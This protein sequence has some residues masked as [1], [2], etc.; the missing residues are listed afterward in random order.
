MH[1]SRTMN[2]IKI[3]ASALVLAFALE[4]VAFAA[5]A[6]PS[7]VIPMQPL[8]VNFPKDVAHVDE[9]YNGSSANPRLILIQ[10]AHT[11]V[12][13]QLN[14]AE[15]ISELVSE[16]K[17]EYVFTEAG[18]GDNSLSALR[19]SASKKIR[20]QIGLEYLRKGRLKGTEYLSLA[21]DLDFKIW[22][23]EDPDL[24]KN[25][26]DAYKFIAENRNATLP[27]LNTLLADSQFL[28]EKIF[29][30]ELRGFDSL[31]LKYLNEKITV[32]DYISTLK[33]Y[34]DS[35]E[36]DIFPAFKKLLEIQRLEKNVRFEKTESERNRFISAF[37][38]FWSRS[39]IEPSPEE[40][41]GSALESIRK[42]G[43]ELTYQHFKRKL[44]LLIASGKITADSFKRE[45]PDLS[46]YIDYADR[47]FEL[48]MRAVVDE[49]KNLE[50]Y[51]SEKL[52]HSSEE[53]DLIRA[54][55]N[56]RVYKKLLEMQAT[57]SEYRRAKFLS[58][59][60]GYTETV[61]ILNRLLMNLQ[62]YYEKTGIINAQLQSSISTS[63]NFYRLAGDR[64][65]V[66]ISEAL[67]KL[68]AEKQSIAILVTGGFHTPNLTE[69]LRTRNISYISLQ[70]QISHE[71]DHD[72]YE[73]M[74]LHQNL[75]ASWKKRVLAQKTSAVS[76]NAFSMDLLNVV[77]RDPV[78]FNQLKLALGA[79]ETQLS[80]AGPAVDDG[81]GSVSGEPDAVSGFRKYAGSLKVSAS[82]LAESVKQRIRK[83]IPGFIPDFIGANAGARLAGQYQNVTPVRKKISEAKLYDQIIVR[84]D[85]KGA[86]LVYRLHEWGFGY[87]MGHRMENGQSVSNESD[88]LITTSVS[89]A[90]VK[91][92]N[93]DIF[94]DVRF[95]IGF[96]DPEAGLTVYTYNGFIED[97]E[98]ERIESEGL[99][100]VFRNV[101]ISKMIEVLSLSRQYGVN[102][103]DI[104]FNNAGNDSTSYTSIPEWA[105]SALFPAS[106]NQDF[107]RYVFAV[108]PQGT[109][110]EQSRQYSPTARIGPESNP[111]IEYFN[112]LAKSRNRILEYTTRPDLN[113]SFRHVLLISDQQEAEILR[114]GSPA[115]RDEALRMLGRSE[116]D[117][118][119]FESRVLSEIST[120]GS[121]LSAEKNNLRIRQISR[122]ENIEIPLLKGEE[123]TRRLNGTTVVVMAGG[124]GTRARIGHKPTYK[125]GGL[126]LL[127][128]T[129][130]GLRALGVDDRNILIVG[131]QND[132]GIK[133]PQGIEVVR[134]ESDN[135]HGS[136]IKA[137]AH[138]RDTGKSDQ[139][140]I[141]SGDNLFHIK[142][143]AE[144]L[145]GENKRAVIIGENQGDKGLR[146]K[147]DR[148]GSIKSY[149]VD[150]SGDG[151]YP[152]GWFIPVSD[153]ESLTEDPVPGIPQIK[154]LER[155][156][157]E[158][159]D[160]FTAPRA[161]YDA[162]L[163][164]SFNL[165]YPADIQNLSEWT[166]ADPRPYG[167]LS[168]LQQSGN[169]YD[170][171]KTVNLGK[172]SWKEINSQI[173][174]AGIL[175][176][177][178][179]AAVWLTVTVSVLSWLSFN[180]FVLLGS[181]SG[182]EFL[183]LEG[184]SAGVF[185]LLTGLLLGLPAA[186]LS[187]YTSLNFYL[188]IRTL[189]APVTDAPVELIP[190]KDLPALTVVV[191]IK[192]EP[193][194]V[195]RRTI[196]SAFE[197]GYPEG[198]LEI[199]LV[200]GSSPQDRNQ[201]YHAEY[202]KLIN[203]LDPEGKVLALVEADQSARKNP[204]SVLTNG[205]S[206]NLNHVLLNPTGKA[207]RTI[208][209]EFFSI[210]D[211]DSYFAADDLRKMMSAVVRQRNESSVE[212]GIIQFR[213][214]VDVK[215]GT[216]YGQFF[217]GMRQNLHDVVLDNFV[218]PL[219][220]DSGFVGN[221]GHSNV[222]L[223][224]A[225]VDAGGF[226]ED[227]KIEDLDMAMKLKEGGYRV[228]YNNDVSLAEG[229]ALGNS[230]FY[231]R[232][233]KIARGDVNLFQTWLFRI[234]FS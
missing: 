233:G 171:I 50:D 103:D 59:D 119:A 13:G 14:I 162:A 25:A 69:M 64:D 126:S 201:E 98:I 141:L 168:T 206:F 39:N 220:F 185:M 99:G 150:Y 135:F 4:Q 188:G 231:T 17:V 217:T 72:R 66:F 156:L 212:T 110:E 90:P 224:S 62:G 158:N 115:N 91:F 170:T 190:D 36:I 209:G 31:R 154:G 205:K 127:E 35:E 5:P 199:L 81:A 89:S 78:E 176:P 106:P 67:D 208:S 34:L 221:F 51:I 118:Q 189:V 174:K 197:S 114:Q 138:V 175:A 75:S 6:S 22:G 24:Y 179:S 195:V 74:L 173:P 15:I 198:K 143:T 230:G 136:A 16:H 23:V 192:N 65:H 213:R 68:R 128:R 165:N 18:M 215:S 157:Y 82:R 196:Q 108:F 10:D 133:W 227:Q 132:N 145:Y 87:W 38:D 146:V 144:A 12:S 49:L 163:N 164:Y 191:P 48:D 137:V 112:N 193:P 77:V 86:D 140:M 101:P 28:K 216:D 120:T 159:H 47:A 44:D 130:N 26:F 184:Y 2:R 21:T 104:R 228:L 160:L 204:N 134:T 42:K 43:G 232:A 214:V 94:G 194:D 73:R 203:Q 33:T 37:Q 85:S 116:E 124:Q 53:R 225:A 117:Q 76:Q 218:T 180:A 226:N 70:P 234:L 182:N 207:T 20:K 7:A 84:A 80:R 45:Y 111:T 167:D 11:N 147:T 8:R 63:L 30:Y 29:N 131:P 60:N 19:S 79:S 169:V 55:S 121:R 107:S 178:K 187:L 200:S 123:L 83:Y 71:T 129:I 210:A 155:L 122:E 139:V 219:R 125:I 229:I 27:Q 152:V 95:K 149:D 102:W 142:S 183:S 148:A 166:K 52:I 153:M 177:L 181:F 92:H 211:A 105:F 1:Q 61:G 56:L 151:P 58:D 202:Q 3:I 100:T 96:S 54:D 9:V 113:L 93:S 223:T 40:A 109:F 57:P 88:V 32:S 46:A 161:R 172:A 41:I 186:V 97:S 222:V